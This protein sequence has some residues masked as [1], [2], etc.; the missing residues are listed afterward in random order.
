MADWKKIEAQIHTLIDTSNAVTG[1]NHNN[2]TDSVNELVSGYGQG[3]GSG[4]TTVR[5]QNK[6]VSPTI[7]QQTVKAD[8]GYTGLGTVTVDAMTTATQATPSISVN[9]SG[10]ITASATQSE[11]YVSAGTKSGTKQLTT[12]AAKTITPSTSSQTAVASGVYTTGAVTVAAIPSSYVQPSGTL[13]ITTNGTHNVKNYESA[14]VS[15]SSSNTGG[16]DTSDANATASHI[17]SPY[18]AYV[19]G[20]KVTGNIATKTQNDLTA[21]GATITVPSGY[22]ASNATKSV[23]TATQATPSISVSNSGLITASSTQTAGYVSAGTKSATN[24]LTTQAAKTITPSTTSQTAVASGVY[25]TGAVTVGAI[26]SD[27]VKPSGTINITTNGTYDIKNYASAIIKIESG[28][29]SGGNTGGGTTY[30]DGSFIPV[31]S[32][33]DGKQYALVA[34]IDGNY[35]YINTTTYNNYTMNATVINV[36]EN[37]GSYIVFES[38]PVLFTAVASGNGFLLKNGNSYLH[39]T[40]SSGTALRVGTTQAVWTVDASENGG[41]SS[42][43]YLEKEDPNAVWLF[44]N[45]GGYDWSIKF[46]TSGSFGY[47]RNGRDNTYSTGFTPFIL[48]ELAEGGSD[49]PSGDGGGNDTP[50]GGSGNGIELPDTIVA[51][52]TPVLSSST[53]AHTCN[54]TTATA[55]GISITVP[56][57]GTYRFKFGCGRTNT[58]GTWT[59]QLYKNGTAISNATATWSSY[60][61]TCSAD[62]QCA[63][64]DK[65]EIYAQSR[66][67]S[68]RSI[69]TQLVACIDWDNGF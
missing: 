11:G 44:N 21:N 10:L 50:S 36:D 29:G 30:P 58:S 63:A 37:T 47:D 22:Y 55:T 20:E 49:A 14:Y 65:I 68:Y 45:S 4:S 2:L 33:T 9:S 23:S 54:S 40:T 51:G 52:D 59:T 1:E 27:Y 31:K 17:L 28:S 60:Q 66:S 6:T 18:T 32:F 25:T 34:L 19:K 67:T 5:L 62:V 38:T 41:F 7:S 43:K 57:A 15:I 48:C 16:I 39:G 24:Q 46:E 13:N 42:G 69:I 8:S 61:G 26:P 12:Q 35:R 56:K 3:S 64:N 53:L